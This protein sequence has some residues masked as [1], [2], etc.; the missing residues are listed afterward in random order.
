MWLV[1][2][3]FILMI[4]GS[5]MVI[6]L[7]YFEFKGCLNGYVVC[8]L[9]LNVFFMDCVFEVE[10]VIMVEEVNVLFVVVVDG[11]LKGI[12]GFE[13]CFLVFCDFINDLCFFIVDGLFIM[14][15]NG[16]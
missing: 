10:W 9:F 1:L 15:I 11:L 12:F 5:V 13:I 2:M 4:M 8:V 7:I 14:V 3:N 6:M 16:I